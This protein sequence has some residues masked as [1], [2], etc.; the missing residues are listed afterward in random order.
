MK[1]QV[2]EMVEWSINKERDNRNREEGVC[3]CQQ[4]TSFSR[5][6]KQLIEIAKFTPE[7][8]D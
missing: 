4:C 8:I 2:G 5:A 1:Q 6:P 3:V 7:K